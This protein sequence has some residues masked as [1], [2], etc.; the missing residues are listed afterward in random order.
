MFFFIRKWSFYQP[1]PPIDPNNGDDNTTGYE[2]TSVFLISLYQYVVVCVAFSISKPFRQP[3][4]T[5]L[6]FVVSLVILSVFNIYITLAN[7]GW[8]FSA[9]DVIEDINMPFRL[10]LICIAFVNGVIT[11]F[12]EKMAVWYISIW[13]KNKK[14]KKREKLYQQ[15]IAIQAQQVKERAFSKAAE[16]RDKRIVLKQQKQE[17]IR[18][19]S[20]INLSHQGSNNSYHPQILLD[21]DQN[22]N[23]LDFDVRSQGS[24]QKQ[25]KRSMAKQPPA[26]QFHSEDPFSKNQR[27][28]SGLGNR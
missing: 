5:N 3:L 7:D 27:R 25:V 8:I 26:E 1:P 4:Y 14:E 12:Y 28:G 20:K 23:R 17:N 21:E 18:S 2:N 22:Q 13:W 9:F 11:F 19:A 24:Q 10:S 16:A 15:E 6:P